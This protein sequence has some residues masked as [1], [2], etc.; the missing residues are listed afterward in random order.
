MGAGLKGVRQRE[1]VDV[2]ASHIQQHPKFYGCVCHRPPQAH[3][4]QAALVRLRRCQANPGSMEP[5]DHPEVDKLDGKV[6]LQGEG[7]SDGADCCAIQCG[8]QDQPA[9]KSAHGHDGRR[10]RL[11]SA[12]DPHRQ[13]A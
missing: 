2:E 1:V 4:Q 6:P 3:D 13:I 7:Q 8:P 11:P 5:G 10:I 12:R 9:Y